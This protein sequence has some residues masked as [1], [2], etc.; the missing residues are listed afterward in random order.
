MGGIVAVIIGVLVAV[1]GFLVMRNPLR[2]SIFAPGEEGYYQRSFFN[3]SSRNAARAFGMLICLFG[4]G[5]AMEGLSSNLKTRYLEAASN[6]LWA[7]IWLTFV[8]LWCIGV[9]FAI[10]NGIKG[11][12]SGWSNWFRMRKAGIELGP[13]SVVPS[14]TPQMQR[15]RLLFTVGLLILVSISLTVALVR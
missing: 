12:A 9:G 15:E 8:G 2:L 14:V 10:W 3:T 1:F 7:I 13:I 4:V 11:R 6:V 5:I